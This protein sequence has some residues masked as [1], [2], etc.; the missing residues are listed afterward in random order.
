MFVTTSIDGLENEPENDKSGIGMINV[1]Q[2]LQIVYPAKHELMFRRTENKLF[3][4][5]TIQLA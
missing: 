5:L 3:T 2:R 1:K 4:Y